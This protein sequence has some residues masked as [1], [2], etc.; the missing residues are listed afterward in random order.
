MDFRSAPTPVGGGDVSDAWRVNGPS[1]PVFLKTGPADSADIFAAESDGL[2]AIADVGD[3]RVPAVL[4][5]GKAGPLA[6]LALEWLEL[7]SPGP[8]TDRDLGRRLAAMHRSTTEIYGWQRDNWIGATRQVNTPASDWAEF[9]GRSR[10]GIQFTIAARYGY[11]GE[12]Q[13]LGAALLEAL[14]R[15]F[16]GHSPPASLLHGDLW[17]GNRAACEGE[18]TVFDPAVYRGD[19][20]TDIAMTRLFGG[21]SP[22]FYKAYDDAW[23]LPDGYA[24]RG[25]VYQ[26]YHVLNHLNLFGTGYLSRA[27]A[28]IRRILEP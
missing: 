28:L 23:P 12:L 18:P 2:A 13:D 7:E 22:E 21:F 10:L 25:L 20:E 27:L 19:R 15:L 3:I 6:W 26:L 16:D 5:F 8:D 1:R 17:G 4:G 11:G 14:P 9:F 24:A